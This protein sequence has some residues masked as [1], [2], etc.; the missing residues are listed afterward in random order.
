MFNLAGYKYFN[1]QKVLSGLQKK[2]LK[3]GFDL[4]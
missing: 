1:S 2:Y 4:F 3:R